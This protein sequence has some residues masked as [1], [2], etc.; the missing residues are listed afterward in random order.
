M[1]RTVLISLSVILLSGCTANI[2]KPTPESSMQKSKEVKTDQA[3]T[4]KYMMYQT[5]AKK[6]A[7]LVQKSKDKQHCFICGMDLVKFYK[8]SHAA[9][10]S[11]GKVHQYCSL[12]CLADHLSKG[13]ELENPQVV[14]V[15]SLKLIPVQEAYYVV[16]G[17]KPGTMSKVS[18]YAFK[19]IEDA[20][21]FQ[22]ENGGK[23][24]DF[25]SAWQEAKKDFK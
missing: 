13:A 19:S 16:G 1:L 2:N 23:I 9:T 11:S 15:T 4:K 10:D 3:G 5:V 18:K 6:D 7:V 17:K 21:K 14:D 20:K 22:A 12:H 24:V 8:T 25:Y